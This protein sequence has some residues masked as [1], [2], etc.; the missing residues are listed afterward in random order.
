MPGFTKTQIIALVSFIVVLISIPITFSLVKKLQIF[1]SRASEQKKVATSSASITATKP[2]SVPTN[3]PLTDL[4]KLIEG[5]GTTTSETPNSDIS[6]IPTIDTS[7]NLAFGPTLSFQ[8]SLE[9]RPANRQAGKV[10]VGIAQGQAAT[11]PTYI[12]TFTTDVPDSGKFNGLSLAGLNPGSVYTAYLKGSSQIDSGITF[13]MNPNESSLSNGKPVTLISG[14]LNEDNVINSADYTIAR[15]YYGTTSASKNW[16][17]KI[18]LNKDKIINNWDLLYINNNM[19]KVGTSGTWISTPKTTSLTNQNPIPPVGGLASPTGGPANFGD[20]L[21]SS[22]PPA[23]IIPEA[24]QGATQSSG[25][26]LYVP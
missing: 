3:S 13:T 7:T 5:D 14:D 22:S 6:P 12:L 9:G 23:S 10:F 11:N 4:Q 20:L 8:V 16:N 25:Y 21:L 2:R 26:W 19:G 24:S 15:G 18:D 1:S 17:E